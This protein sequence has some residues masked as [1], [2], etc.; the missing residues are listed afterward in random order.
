VG[1]EF[2]YP[3]RE[4]GDWMVHGVPRDVVKLPGITTNWAIKLL[5]HGWDE[6]TKHLAISRS[7]GMFVVGLKEVRDLGPDHKVLWPG[8]SIPTGVISALKNVPGPNGRA[9]RDTPSV[10]G[11]NGSHKAPIKTGKE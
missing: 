2:S 11:P 5:Q 1:I 9:D 4:G 8:V 7:E 3:R 10:G 6:Y